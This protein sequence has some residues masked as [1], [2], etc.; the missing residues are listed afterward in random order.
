MSRSIWT[1]CL[2]LALAAL[3]VGCGPA[4]EDRLLDEKIVI[5]DKISDNWGTV[6]EK[7]PESMK[8]AI[9]QYR[10]EEGT[11]GSGQEVGESGNRARGSRHQAQAD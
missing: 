6:K 3:V 5:M 9:A 1:G 2:I 10:P 8:A 11:R 4:E 7:D